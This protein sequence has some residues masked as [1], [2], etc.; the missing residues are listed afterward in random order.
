[1]RRPFARLLWLASLSLLLACAPG[2]ITIGLWESAGS[3]GEDRIA[4]RVHR[5]RLV[6]NILELIV[7]YQGEGPHLVLVDL[8]AAT[9]GFYEGHPTL[10]GE[11]RGEREEDL[12]P[13]HLEVREDGLLGDVIQPEVKAP[14]A[15]A[16][17]DPSAPPP[18]PPK[19]FW[20]NH[21]DNEGSLILCLRRPG[22][23]PLYVEVQSLGASGTTPLVY[24]GAGLIT[25]LTFAADVVTFPFQVVLMIVF[26]S[27]I[28]DIFN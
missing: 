7:D 27:A 25:P 12:E 23:A 20:F 13:V 5:A 19:L 4:R 16:E 1:M 6:G 18:S 3:A 8:G 28:D 14:P 15:E 21:G 10:R 17:D 2:C 9:R 22:Q 11:D 26:A 24:V